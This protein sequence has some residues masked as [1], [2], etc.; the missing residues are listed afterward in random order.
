MVTVATSPFSIRNSVLALR[1]AI[2]YD[3]VFLCDTDIPYDDTWDRSG[4]GNRAIVQRQIITELNNRNIAYK[5]LSGSREE[6][7]QNVLSVIRRFNKF[8]DQPAR[9]HD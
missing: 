7:V 3:V 9:D 2:R 6:R 8:S 5:P 1:S 4:E